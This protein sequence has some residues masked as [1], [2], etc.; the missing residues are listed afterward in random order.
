[1]LQASL[2][3]QHKMAISFPLFVSIPLGYLLRL[4]YNYVMYVA[5]INQEPTI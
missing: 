1:M 4:D 2:K 5:T 3:W